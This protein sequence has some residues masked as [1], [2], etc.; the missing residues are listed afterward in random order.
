MNISQTAVR[1]HCSELMGQTG[2]KTTRGWRW[3]YSPLQLLLTPVFTSVNHLVGH[4]CPRKKKERDRAAVCSENNLR[5]NSTL[6][7]FHL[8]LFFQLCVWMGE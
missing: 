3:V 6:S 1:L 4:A 7:R 5:I 2:H 8:V